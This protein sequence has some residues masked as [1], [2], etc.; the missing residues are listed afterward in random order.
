[1]EHAP[2]ALKI[3]TLPRARALVCANALLVFTFLLCQAL[4]ASPVLQALS[5]PPP[6]PAQNLCAR[7]ALQEL[8][9]AQQAQQRR[10]RAQCAP[11]ASSVQQAQACAETAPLEDMGPQQGCHQITAPDIAL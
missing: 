1:M 4:N 5:D 2:A 10:L 7:P 6:H 8:T 11:P 9:Q 3:Y